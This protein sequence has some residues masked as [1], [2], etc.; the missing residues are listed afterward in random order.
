MRI[1][2]GLL[3]VR[4]L[5]KVV[6]TEPEF[7]YRFKHT[8]I[9]E[10]A[11]R[12][13]LRDERGMLHRKTGQILERIYPDADK[14]LAPRLG[15]HF[16]RAGDHDRAHEYL[17]LA[18]NQTLRVHAYAEAV[19]FFERALESAERVQEGRRERIGESYARLGRALEL[20]GKHSEALE[21]Y[22]DMEGQARREAW[23]DLELAAMIHQ[24]TLFST[25]SPLMNRER[26]IRL[27]QNT[28]EMAQEMGEVSA[29]IKSRRNL[30][31]A[32]ALT[33]GREPEAIQ[34][35]ERALEL[36]EG[37]QDNLLLA[38]LYNDV[39]RNHMFCGNAGRARKLL[40]AAEDRWRALENV[41]MLVD[42]LASTAGLDLY[43]GNL[44]AVSQR[45]Q[46]AGRLARETGN[47]WAQAYSSTFQDAGAFRKG[48]YAR[49]L[50]IAEK[51][52]EVASAA[53]FT[54]IYMLALYNLAEL[55]LELG[56]LD[57]AL[58][59]AEQ[60]RDAAERL[61]H[62][63]L[64]Q[65]LATMAKVWMERGDLEKAQ[66]LL[67]HFPLVYKGSEDC[68][69]IAYIQPTLAMAHLALAK[70]DWDEALDIARLTM[71]G[72]EKRGLR[73]IIPDANWIAGE[74]LL[75]KDDSEAAAEVLGRGQQVAEAMGA[76][77]ILWKV[78]VSRAAAEERLGELQK[79]ER[80][81]K[82]AAGIVRDMAQSL[83]S[84]GYGD[85]FLARSDVRELLEAA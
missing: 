30:A 44:D 78:M 42:S 8:L 66:S 53:G 72:L 56:E 79:A 35:G 17:M 85:S 23:P 52:Q 74:A 65:P 24:A 34:H 46:E 18:G 81:R 84:T 83:E 25:P 31:L 64:A 45:G 12:S 10:S 20:A 51:S 63:W 80:L 70:G 13:L 67:G 68:F 50:E 57:L 29:E 9:H 38:F 5:V 43:M 61:D 36:A 16:T 48:E 76:R 41:P 6:Q 73:L 7:E 40:E 82:D 39:G 54:V 28:L 77:R 1:N 37:H 60:C 69:H 2:L 22:Q 33:P 59:R 27:S 49:A 4:G 21:R 32:L 3:E 55:F 26:G 58:G 71:E 11:Y 75:A 62:N 15:H 19:G 47:A 14:E